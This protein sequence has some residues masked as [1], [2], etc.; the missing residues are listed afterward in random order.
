MPQLEDREAALSRLQAIKEEERKG[1]RITKEVLRKHCKENKLYFTPHLNDVLYLHFKGY[2]VIENLEEYTGLKCLWLENNALLRIEN[3]EKQINLRCL[4]LH[5]NIIKKIENLEE[6]QL[7]DTL[8]LSHNYVEKIENLSILPVLHTL[9]LSHNK[10]ETVEDIS[11]LRD[12]VELSVVDLSH[13]NLQDESVVQVFASMQNLRVLNLMGNPV[14]GKIRNYRNVITVECKNL[15][16]LDDRPVFPRDRACA[17]AW[18]TG[19]YEASE[20]VRLEWIENDRLKIQRSVEALLHLKETRKAKALEEKTEDENSGEETQTEPTGNYIQKATIENHQKEFKEEENEI[21]PSISPRGLKTEENIKKLNPA[22]GLDQIKSEDT[23][24]NGIIQECKEKSQE[25]FS[26]KKE[27]YLDTNCGNTDSA[28]ENEACILPLTS[29]NP[30]SMVDLEEKYLDTNCGNTDSAGENEACILPLTS[31]NPTS[32]VDLEPPR[33]LIEVV[34]NKEDATENLN[35]VGTKELEPVDNIFKRSSTN[36]NNKLLK[37]VINIKVD[38]GCEEEKSESVEVSP[39]NSPEDHSDLIEI[40]TRK[41]KTINVEESL[42]TESNDVSVEVFRRP[43]PLIEEIFSDDDN[44][45]GSLNNCVE[46]KDNLVSVVVKDDSCNGTDTFQVE[47]DEVTIKEGD[48]KI[49]QDSQG[50]KET[51]SDK[52][53]YIDV[54]VTSQTAAERLDV[55]DIDSNSSSSYLDEI[56]TLPFKGDFSCCDE[57][58][59]SPYELEAKKTMISLVDW[60][61]LLGRDSA[62][63]EKTEPIREVDE[64][65]GVG[66][67]DAKGSN[68]DI[69]DF[70]KI[71]LEETLNNGRKDVEFSSLPDL[72][73]EYLYKDEYKMSCKFSSTPDLNTFFKAESSSRVSESIGGKGKQF[74][75][76]NI[77]EATGDYER[78]TELS[79]G[80]NTVPKVE[81]FAASETNEDRVPCL[82]TGEITNTNISQTVHGVSSTANEEETKIQHEPQVTRYVNRSLELQIASSLTESD[83]HE[84]EQ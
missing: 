4:Y 47:C 23:E 43:K 32:M 27:K 25:M 6:L 17:E 7:L 31:T 78:G 73:W 24:K 84:N 54:D 77:Q 68:S 38:D 26:T 75:K 50:K 53:L 9:N 45:D 35:L 82:S 42:I 3:L 22:V 56:E 76:F 34:R 51:T 8:N 30:T 55:F 69:N 79:I 2:T 41:Y 11:H 40:S 44:D 29:T 39:L 81:K 15:Q 60:Q 36:K 20:K 74:H 37:H 48:D 13:N 57:N 5:N 58:R 14:K 65:V 71:H 19:G 59:S 63:D 67:T 33:T 52:R 83:T 66:K 16:Y 46:G 72:D 49:N 28:G 70:F 62:E 21:A 18:A 10:L 61:R 1:P 80:N 64:L 12:C